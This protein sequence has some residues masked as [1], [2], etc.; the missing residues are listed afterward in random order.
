MTRELRSQVGLHYL[1]EKRLRESNNKN[2]GGDDD[3]DDEMTIFT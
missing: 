3:D 1:H 2:Y